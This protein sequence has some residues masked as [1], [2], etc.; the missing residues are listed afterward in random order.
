MALISELVLPSVRFRLDSRPFR[1]LS[2]LI[3]AMRSRRT[4][5]VS[6]ALSP[7]PQRMVV[8]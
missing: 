6:Y 1:C 7:V 2:S 3:K 8:V 5:S 4:T